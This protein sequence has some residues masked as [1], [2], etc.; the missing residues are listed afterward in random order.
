MKEFKFVCRDIELDEVLSSLGSNQFVFLQSQNNSGLTHFLKQLMTFLWRED[1]VCFYVDSESALSISSQIIGEVALFSTAD[2]PEENA[3]SKFLCKP[4]KKD[5][6][7]AV[8]TSCLYALDVIPILPNIGT[9]ANSLVLSITEALDADYEHLNDFKTEKAVEKFFRILSQE[10]KKKIYLLIDNPSQMTPDT[11]SFLALLWERYHIRILFAFNSSGYLNGAELLSK[12]LGQ[13]GTN[14][15]EIG[16]IPTEFKRPDNALIEALY[17]CYGK[18]FP[19]SVIPVFE[20]A[21]RNIHVIMAHILGLPLSIADVEQ[22]FRYLL[23]VLSIFECFVPAYILF[24]VLRTENLRSQNAS[25]ADFQRLI[26]CALEQGYLRARQI[27]DTEADM[28]YAVSS[29]CFPS[30]IACG[31]VEKQKIAADAIAT[32]D[33]VCDILSIPLL[34]FGIA[35]L[36]HDYSHCK[37]YILALLKI[38][39][40]KNC[41]DLSYLN[42]LSYFEKL[43]ELLFVCGTYYDCGVYDKPYHLLQNHKI[44]SRKKSY[45]VMEALVCERLHT[46]NY[47]EKLE[48]LFC[49]TPHGDGKCLLAAVLFV[50]YLNSDDASKYKCFFSPNSEYY[51]KSFETCSNYFYLLRNVSYYIE[52]VPEAIQNY[53]KCLA[54]FR[55]KDPVNYNRTISNYLCYLMRNDSDELAVDRMERIVDE[56]RKILD[57]NDVAYAYLNNNYG[58]YIMRYTQEDP[59]AYF[60]SIPRSMGTTETP[61]IYAQINLA[62]HTAKSDPQ[63]ALRIMDAVEGDVNLTPVPRTKQFYTIN[64]AFIEFLSGAFPQV[65]LDK[66]AAN[67]LRGNAGYAQGLIDNYSMLRDGKSQLDAAQYKALSLPGYLF[68]RYFNAS[69]LLAYF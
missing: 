1:S 48:K 18:E 9:I 44:F 65:E 34:K 39:V 57:Y 8:I 21:G 27:G 49:Q 63:R 46:D 14:S 4:N 66:I 43:D 11:I 55:A 24:P 6:V 20:S 30:G 64:R 29:E 12:L 17:Q 19:P 2:A 33:S 13:I 52:D 40:R 35:W 67:P 53:E 25:D 15:T 3:I 62:L 10:K 56:V 36:E 51:Y 26:S 31:F 69:K 60:A 7:F 22:P 68:Y 50:A 54:L 16:R 47:V 58:I 38:Q 61:Y 42:Q 5:I 32:M 37:Q 45:R 59:T 41:V 28:E 23:Q